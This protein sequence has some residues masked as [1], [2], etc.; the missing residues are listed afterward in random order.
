MKTGYGLVAA[1]LMILLL[2]SASFGYTLSGD[3]SG[4][5]WFGG[6][7][8]IYAFSLDILNPQ[9]Y[10]GLALLGNGSYFIFNV[11]EG[12]YILFAFQDRDGDL[13]PSI[14]DYLGYYG[15]VFPE[16]VE[17]TG[18]V[19]ALDIEVEP[20]PFTT[21]SGALSCPAG[22][23]GPTYILAASDPEF[24]NI[25]DFTI[26]LTFDGNADYTLF[27][28]PG[29]YYILAYLDADFSFS[30]TS[31]DPQI[32][33]GAPDE[34]A[35]VNVSTGSAE[36]IDLPMMFPP[37]V[38]LTLTPTAP[39]IIIPAAGGVF[40]Y[41]ISGANNGSMTADLQVW[42]DVTL[43]DGSST[44]PVLGPVNLSL[45]GGFTA[46]RDREQT[47]PGSAPSGQYTYHAYAGM[48]PA[49]VW[50]ESYFDFEKSG[51]DA[52][53]PYGDWSTAG[54]DLSD[55]G[56]PTITNK[57][58]DPPFK[59]ILVETYPNPFNP[60]TTISYRLSKAERVQL[61][62]FDLGGCEIA[63]PVDGLQDAGR[64]EIIFDGSGLTSGVYFYRLQAGES[65][66]AGKLL[67]M[68]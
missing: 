14:D 60:T 42:I 47:V 6:I 36:N 52:L 28:D 27:V 58:A 26:P 10:I 66:S 20:L 56:D 19:G 5:E 38:S 62:V 22:A 11:A 64:H 3:I 29:E 35:L 40:E 8:Y 59:P 57:T 55:W 44:A 23:F 25:V 54:E 24:E 49:I 48:Y 13:L 9:F 51:T 68:K 39:P 4:A 15:D 16:L 65:S 46:E 7:T 18:N 21:I 45:P 2:S 53:S 17:V 67:L 50:V 63:R 33:Y 1:L 12:D 43:P 41:T 37:D 30:R 61:R 34:P 31:A 32:F